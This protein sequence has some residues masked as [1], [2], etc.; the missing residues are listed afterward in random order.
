LFITITGGKKVPEKE[1]LSE[2]AM[3]R[4]V[5]WPK[6]WPPGDPVPWIFRI[7]DE[8]MVPVAKAELNYLIKVA[9]AQ[10]EMYEELART[11]K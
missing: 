8:W 7:R 4:M 1:K 2:F 11:L 5:K 3:E 10:I 6:P 9:H